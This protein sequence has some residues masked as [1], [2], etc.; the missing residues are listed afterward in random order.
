MFDDAVAW[1]VAHGRSGQWGDKPW[2]SNPER[3][4]FVQKTAAED[5]FWIAEIDG[6]PAGTLCVAEEPTRYITPADERE[7]YV[8]LL[9]TAR[10]YAG[11]RV[12][13]TL[14]DHARDIARERGIDLVRVDC[15]AGGDGS[16]IR[17]YTRNGFTP[18]ERFHVGD[19]PGQLFEQRLGGTA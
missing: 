10:E 5:G 15:Y 13:S 6:N 18:T 16:L 11:H 12:G 4:E 8:R 3:V 2:S 19:W 9:L 17:Y 7:L 1:L 14:L